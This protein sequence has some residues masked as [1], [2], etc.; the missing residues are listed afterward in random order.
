M[1]ITNINQVVL[2]KIIIIKIRLRIM[3]SKARRAIKR[4][5]RCRITHVKVIR[6]KIGVIRTIHDVIAYRKLLSISGLQDQRF[7]TISFIC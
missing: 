6:T 5:C 1:A 2:I 3:A 4:C 7:K